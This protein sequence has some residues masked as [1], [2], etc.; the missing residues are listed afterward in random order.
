MTQEGLSMVSVELARRLAA[1]GDD[2]VLRG[3][4]RLA[5]GLVA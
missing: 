3:A 4:A 5:S 2:R 1:I